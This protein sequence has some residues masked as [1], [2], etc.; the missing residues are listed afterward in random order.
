M[1]I[2]YVIEKGDCQSVTEDIPT[3]GDHSCLVA[4]GTLPEDV[5]YRINEIIWNN[6][7]ALS[8]VSKDMDQLSPRFAVAGQS[9]VHPGSLRFWN[10]PEMRELRKKGRR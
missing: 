8:E 6:R 10:S 3:L 2:T 5:V 1:T 9:K 4:Q 7:S